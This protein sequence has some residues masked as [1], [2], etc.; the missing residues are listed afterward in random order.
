M[1]RHRPG[2][3]ARGR[4]PR[5]LPRAARLAPPA[6]ALLVVLVATA[7]LGGCR[8]PDDIEAPTLALADLQVRQYSGG[9]ALVDAVLEVANPNDFAISLVEV[10]LGVGVDSVQ[11]GRLRWSG[12]VSLAATATTRTTV[13]A[14]WSVDTHETVFEALVDRR[15]VDYTLTGTVHLARGV[16]TRGVPVTASG[17]LGARR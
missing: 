8:T 17:R 5:P 7:G 10:D 13:E 9:R 6:L 2:G 15:A 12:E 3:A 1:K 14:D 4:R 11:V 16:L